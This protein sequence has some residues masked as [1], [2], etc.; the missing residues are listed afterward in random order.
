L[1]L[2]YLDSSA[3]VKRY[4]LEYGSDIVSDVYTK[5]LN[6]D[7]RIAFSTWNIGEVLGALNKYYR[8][9]WLS[10]D[11]YEIARVQFLWETVRLLK[12][13][14]LRIVPVKTKLLINCLPLVEKHQLYIADALQLVTAKYVGAEVLYTGDR[15]LAKV[16][17]LEGLKSL[18]LGQP[19]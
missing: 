7:L 10:K 5:A 8:R 16:A 1:T 11:E 19:S 2:A 14:I 3:I 13:R 6:G 12:L 15:G 4:I 17:E 9:G 18:Y